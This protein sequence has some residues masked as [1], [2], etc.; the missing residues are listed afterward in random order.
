MVLVSVEVEWLAAVGSPCI[1][2]DVESVESLRS[3]D[4]EAETHLVAS[5][6]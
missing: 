1:G 5:L 3:P 2:M 6:L 4:D